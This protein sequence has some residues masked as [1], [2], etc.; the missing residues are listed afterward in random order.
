MS[1]VNKSLLHIIEEGKKG[2]E[3]P[4]FDTSFEDS[5]I[6]KY[7]QELV[8]GGVKNYALEDLQ[9][10]ITCIWLFYLNFNPFCLID[11]ILTGY[12]QDRGIILSE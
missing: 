1:M 11:Q 12:K 2:K 10:D 7:H 8:A 9:K 4:T 6:E 3:G 5:L